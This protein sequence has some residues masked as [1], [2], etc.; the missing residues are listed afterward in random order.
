MNPEPGARLATILSIT[1]ITL[2]ITGVATTTW[3][4]TTTTPAAALLGALVTTLSG[5]VAVAALDMAR[6]SQATAAVD[7]REETT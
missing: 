6:I 2:T 1:S 5:L 7:P 4:A 3:A